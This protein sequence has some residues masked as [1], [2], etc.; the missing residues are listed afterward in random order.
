M[1]VLF[2][3]VECLYVILSLTFPLSLG[4]ALCLTIYDL[5]HEIW[6]HLH[7]WYLYY[8]KVRNK[9]LVQGLLIIVIIIIN[10][11]FVK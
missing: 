3:S 1:L 10:R 6:E 5:K 11:M 2:F 8:A 4:V 9:R 7:F